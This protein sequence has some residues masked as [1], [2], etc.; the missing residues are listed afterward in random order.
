MIVREYHVHRAAF[1]RDGELTICLGNEFEGYVTAIVELE[2]ILDT[3]RAYRMSVYL[4][5]D[6]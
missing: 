6:G 5:G 2:D 3:S 1:L 4:N